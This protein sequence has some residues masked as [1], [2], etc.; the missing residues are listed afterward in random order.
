M[1]KIKLDYSK[2]K[3]LSEASHERGVDGRKAA[4][5][6]P[7]EWAWTLAA[8]SFPKGY[9]LTLAE[10]KKALIEAMAYEVISDL[11]DNNEAIMMLDD[12]N[13]IVF[14]EFS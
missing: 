13:N 7:S 6:N 5:D 11:I 1:K 4:T 8:V 14:K 10:F 3:P 9:E 2:I 12:Q